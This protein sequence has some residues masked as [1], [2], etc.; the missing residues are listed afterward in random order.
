MHEA[1]HMR[2]PSLLCL[3]A[4]LGVSAALA[5]PS[6]RAQLAGTASRLDVGYSLLYELKFAEAREQ[7][8]AWEETHPDDPFGSASKAASYLYEE[9]YMQGVLSSEFFLDDKR[10]LGGITGKPDE[11]RRAAFIA[12]N[13]R[14]HEVARRRLKVN[15]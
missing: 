14:A 5:W 9:L 1:N 13:Q 3:L 11:N 12:A 4:T 10:F 7:F 2:P 6:D 15:A 8:T